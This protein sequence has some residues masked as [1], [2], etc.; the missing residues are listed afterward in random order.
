MKPDE[1]LE[2]NRQEELER[3]GAD[4]EKIRAEIARIVAATKN[5]AVIRNNLFGPNSGKFKPSGS[6]FGSKEFR[7][8]LAIY[9]KEFESKGI[10]LGDGR[11]A[12]RTDFKQ[13]IFL[14]GSFSVDG[15]EYRVWGDSNGQH[16]LEGK[17]PAGK[18][19]IQ[20]GDQTC[21]LRLVDGQDEIAEIDV[22]S[23]V[24]MYRLLVAQQSG[25]E[26]RSICFLA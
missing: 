6:K 8:A 1:N 24:G 7:T 13:E 25:V 11:S 9:S 2:N 19:H 14:K 17:I 3:T 21:S 12:S 5:A 26:Q 23:I 4:A 15:N 22:Q 16:Y 18:S 20:F 10:T